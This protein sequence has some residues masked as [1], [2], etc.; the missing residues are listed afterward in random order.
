MLSRPVWR[1]LAATQASI[2]IV[3]RD[4]TWMQDLVLVNIEAVECRYTDNLTTFWDGLKS[5][6]RTPAPGFWEPGFGAGL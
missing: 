6:T 3:E 1:N 5:A 4:D 2:P